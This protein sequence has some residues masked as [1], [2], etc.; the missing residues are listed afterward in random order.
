MGYQHGQILRDS[1]PKAAPVRAL[2]REA[3]LGEACSVD[4]AAGASRAIGGVLATV[5]QRI[6][7]RF[8]SACEAMDGLADGARSRAKSFAAP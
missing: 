5:G 4:S 7:K 1:I 6:A 8:P 2:R 3:S